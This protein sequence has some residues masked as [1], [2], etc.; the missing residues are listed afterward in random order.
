MKWTTLV[1]LLVSLLPAGALSAQAETGR[2]IGTVTDATTAS[3]VASASISVQGTNRGALSGSTGSF[4][5]TQVPAGTHT[6]RATV[7]GYRTSEQEVVVRAGQDVVVRVTLQPQAVELQE[8]VAVGY[9]TQRRGDLTGSVASVN[10]EALER[11]PVTSLDQMLQGT[12]PGVQVTQASSAPGGG[13]S[14]RIRGGSSVSESV[15][16]EPLY[17]IDGFPIEVDYSADN[18]R[19]GGGRSAGINVPT[20]PIATLNPRDIESIEILK[21]ASATAIYGSRAANG[22]VIITTRR[23]QAG[24]PRVNF[25]AFT[26]VQSVAKRYDLLSG[27]EYARFANEWWAAQYPADQPPEPIYA[28]PNAVVDTD[29]QSA[30]FR[31]APLQSY[32]LTVTGGTS[33]DNATRYAIS[34]GVF[35]QDGVVLG[36][37]FQR[38]SLRLNLNQDI[39]SR[40]RLGTTLTGSRVTTTFAQTDG[41]ISGTEGSVVAAALQQIPTLPVRDTAGNYTTMVRNAPIQIS[42]TDVQNPVAVLENMRDE[43]G[44]LRLLSNTFAE[45]S[46]LDGLRLRSSFGA[47]ITNRQ[48]DTYWPRE[49]LRGQQTGGQAVRGRNESTSFLNEN[50][51]SFNRNLGA[52]HSI[53]SVVGYTW[54]VQ[55]G[56]ST[57]MT[58]ENFL[59]DIL[60]YYDIG[61]GNRAGGPLVS[62][63][64]TRTTIESFLGRVNYNLLDRYLFTL[65]GRYDGSSRF[66]PDRKWGFFPSGAFAWRVS[67]EPFMRDVDAVSDLRLRVSYGAAGNAAISPYQSLAVLGARQTNFGNA[68]ETG[69]R[70]T[71][72]ANQELG[73]ETTHQLDMGVDFGLMGNLFTLAADRYIRRTEDLLMQI[74]LPY[75]TGFRSAFQNAGTVE[76]RGFELAL[77]FNPLRGDG[78]ATPRWSHS[79]NYSRNRNEVVDLGGLEILRVRGISTHFGFP[80]THVRLGQP[81]G[82]FYG[83]KTDGIFRDSVEANAY[84]A[85]LP[86][87]RFQ[88]G[89]ARVLD[90]SGPDG[91]PDG[92]INEF[93]LTFIGDPNPDFNIGWTNSFAWR[94]FELTSLLQGAFGADVLNIN[95]TRVEGGAPNSNV[96]R[97]RYVNRWTPENPN[98]KHPRVGSTSSTIGSNYVDTMLEDGSYL[99]LSSLTLGYS[100]PSRWVSA[101]GFR[102]TRVY[103]TGSNLL[104]WSGYSGYNPDVS[105]MGVGNINRGVDV[106]AY[107]LARTVT[108]GVNFGY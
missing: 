39:G 22:V 105:G 24:A 94:G 86:N 47:N 95:L 3:P 89:E 30:I 67:S 72:L 48:R 97:D 88:A 36:S 7:I 35:D 77:G 74:D 73:W 61:A 12:A 43:L 51:L 101:R 38:L 23:G 14:I 13:I 108:L 50:T 9:G 84:S 104:T 80:G 65:T 5:I 92:V 82:V 96:T 1:C 98:A 71:R 59:N 46:I 106:G 27:P 60:D 100:L 21:D 90:L 6:L 83:Y 18:N 87:R 33:G 53:N 25:E 70:Q 8:I 10:M 57:S 42:P 68:I 91:V 102:E 56:S 17:V 69:Y 63:G 99:R 41:G 54:Q 37:S 85:T 58:N 40:L 44:D 78:Q 103:V 11:Q 62:S 16:N 55:E 79:F 64:A 45:F 26:G 15:S 20:N 52:A 75:E 34:G 31:N 66:G 4:V 28:N 29:W 49:T 32:Q 19:L 93:D 81:I 76:N 2:I 107:P